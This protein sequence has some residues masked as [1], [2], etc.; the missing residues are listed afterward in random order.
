M[1][2]PFVNVLN[3][4]KS[5]SKFYEKIFTEVQVQ[6]YNEDPAWIPLDTLLAMK[7]IYS[8]DWYYY[9]NS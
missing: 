3:T 8:K 9:G 2:S 6:F 5:Y 1:V 7:K 4:R